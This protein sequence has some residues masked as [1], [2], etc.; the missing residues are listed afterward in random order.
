MNWGPI[1]SAL[2]YG[3]SV[4][5]NQP[6]SGTLPLSI[7]AL[8]LHKA[9]ALAACCRLYARMQAELLATPDFGVVVAP[10]KASLA[11]VA[12]VLLKVTTVATA[13]YCTDRELAAALS[14]SSA[15]EH[16]AHMLLGLRPTEPASRNIVP[17]LRAAVRIFA[18][19][20]AIPG[21]RLALR[22][23]GVPGPSTDF[24]LASVSVEALR[25]IDGGPTYGLPPGPAGIA[26]LL[27][28]RVAN[29]TAAAINPTRA[30]R[31]ELRYDQLEMIRS[32]TLSLL[33][34]APSGSAPS[35][36][37]GGTG[38]RH[39]F[40]P[41]AAIYRLGLRASVAA[42]AAMNEMWS[43]TADPQGYVTLSDN[44]CMAAGLGAAGL[45]CAHDAL[46]QLWEERQRRRGLAGRQQRAASGEAG[47]SGSSSAGV[48][49]GPAAVLP[50]PNQITNRRPQPWWA[51]AAAAMDQLASPA[52]LVAN[53]VGRL[54]YRCDVDLLLCCQLGKG[55]FASEMPPGPL[56]PT[57]PPDVARALSAGFLP[58][59]A[60][61]LRR[62]PGILL[63]PPQPAEHPQPHPSGALL[64][65]KP[66]S[67]LLAYGDCREAAGL[68]ETLRELLS[69]GRSR[70]ADA[71][72]TKE[73]SCN[74]DRLLRLSLSLAAD[75]GRW[76][77]AT[78]AAAATAA[79]SAAATAV[80][81]AGG[82]SSSSAAGANG[83]TAQLQDLLAF[84]FARW[85]PECAVMDFMEAEYGAAAVGGAAGMGAAAGAGGSGSAQ[86]AESARSGFWRQ[87]LFERAEVAHVLHD[88][89]I[90]TSAIGSL[91][92]DVMGPPTRRLLRRLIARFPD[93]MV[94]ALAARGRC[95]M[96]PAASLFEVATATDPPLASFLKVVAGG[97]GGGALAKARAMLPL[98]PPPPTSLS[99]GAP[100]PALLAGA[101]SV[102]ALAGAG[103]LPALV[104]QLP[105]ACSSI[106]CDQRRGK[107]AAGEA[108]RLR[109]CKGGCGC[110][111]FCSD[112]C[113]LSARTHG[114]ALFCGERP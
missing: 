67:W 85:L 80:P 97:S 10:V 28:A 5:D 27:V 70:R 78:K 8:A 23:M 111:W 31:E 13:P 14:A 109:P 21:N 58:A 15:L 91:D 63:E 6:I 104:Q 94:P 106:Y 20:V 98:P 89:A 99:A 103:S 26:S 45:V 42:V 108:R 101:P 2:A 113:E 72:Q 24:L 25:A 37:G 75:G 82:G 39:S 22:R 102:A 66:L 56:P 52:S 112:A 81:S 105:R 77:F 55:Q 50:P 44:A 54:A 3:L 69:L 35:G 18:W 47:E 100:P 40:L 36:S 41:P 60:N 110:A 30:V 46:D 95:G 17:Q 71:G 53:G 32:W 83:P 51:A 68:V 79:Q 9:G 33:P 90:E 73:F 62:W 61:L 74:L 4:V 57:P 16:F 1:A 48:P 114:H 93:T 34:G 59:L 11:K 49:G 86:P 107:G 7:T 12:A 96:P 76:A 29:L 87:V 92:P 84:A 38:R 65:W 64:S 88:V 19:H 43:H